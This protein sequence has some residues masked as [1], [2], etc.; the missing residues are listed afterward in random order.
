LNF[1]GHKENRKYLLLRSVSGYLGTVLFFYATTHMLTSDAAM[2]NKLSPVFVFILSYFFLKEK[3]S[4]VQLLS[5]VISIIGATL[6]IKPQFKISI[7]P[8]AAGLLS[9]IISAIAYIYISLIGKKESTYT[10]V[11]YFSCFSTI[12]S[13]PVLVHNY[14][15]PSITE[16]FL[17]L[18]LG[19]L[20]TVG[21]IALTY[22][23][24]STQASEISIYD[25]SNIIFSSFLGYIFFLEKPDYY[26]ILGGIAIILSSLLLFFYDKK[27]TR[28]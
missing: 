23:Y 4:G 7:L 5:L 21:Q 12:F 19:S 6:I 14:T 10:V 20:A 22:A 26:S 11:F 27:N 28:I 2:L 17:L 13:I 3:I 1:R 16:L 18:L 25:Y 8:A 15:I 9:A 24:N